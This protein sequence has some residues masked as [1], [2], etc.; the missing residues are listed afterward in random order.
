VLT[1]R[2]IHELAVKEISDYLDMGCFREP[3]KM[4]TPLVEGFTLGFK[5]ARK[6]MKEQILTII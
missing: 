1:D 2:D 4:A 6:L 3:E 5:Q